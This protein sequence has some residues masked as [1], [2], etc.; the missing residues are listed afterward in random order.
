M[1]E[2][3][4]TEHISNE[5]V[6]TLV[7]ERY[8]LTTIRTRQWN[9]MGHIMRGD[10]LQREI[11]HC[12]QMKSRPPST[13]QKVSQLVQNCKYL[14]EISNSTTVTIIFKRDPKAVWK[15]S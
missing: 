4:W 12:V 6:L 11:I 8:L 2:I 14:P 13:Q 1:E 7:E 10:S 15:Y 5:K 9:W 3:S